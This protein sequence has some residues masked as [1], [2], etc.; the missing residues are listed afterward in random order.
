MDRRTRTLITTVGL[1][2]LL[3]ATAIGSTRWRS[4]AVRLRKAVRHRRN[5]LEGAFARMRSGLR[6]RGTKPS[7]DRL[8]ARV[9]ARLGHVI[10]RPQSIRV[11]VSD[12]YVLLTGQ[13]RTAE[14]DDAAREL[15]KVR[16][17]GEVDARLVV[18]K[19]RDDGG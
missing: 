15:R 12:D 13:A 14:I 2:T 19:D 3:F 8:T 6:E 4:T 17:V 11:A 7:D 18:R 1:V 10:D 5:R 16:G 9:R